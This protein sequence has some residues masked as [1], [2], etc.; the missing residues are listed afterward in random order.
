DLWTYQEIQRNMGHENLAIPH[1]GNVSDGWMFSP[2][3]FLGG[4]MDA[5]YA[6]RQAANEPV[7][8]MIQTKGSSDT[9]PYLSPNDEFA[10][11]ELFNNMIN[12]GMPSQLKHSFYRQGL[13]EG[14]KLEKLLGTNPYKMGIVAG[15]DI[16]SGYSGNEEWGWNG[17]HGS[18]D[19]T[20]AKRLTPGMNPSGEPASVVGSAGTTAIW[21][22]ENTRASLF[23]GMK[24]K[25]TYGTSGTMIRLRFFGGWELPSDL[26]TDP[27]FV[28]MAY[29]MGVPMGG[30]LKEKPSSVKAP[31]FAIWALKDSES[32][33]LDRIQIIKVFVNKWDR[34]DEK[35][36][37][38]ALSDGRKV[39]PKTGKA[40]D[41]GNTVN[42][43]KATYT[44]DIG[45]SQL[46]AVWTDPDFD[47]SQRASYYVRVLEIPT[48][49]WTT[50]DAARN[51]L[52]LP[53]DVPAVIQE[54]AWSSPIWYT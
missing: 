5:R 36:Y 7:F 13:G 31:S 28:K 6:E 8:E 32:G 35:I 11:F 16:H 45:D 51:N 2:N 50:Y 12:V 43:K 52:P 53:T 40:P 47:A 41:V 24:N 49:R 42:V 9:H 25:E 33:N 19:D 29:N 38:V 39:D 27:E 4:P 44:N 17:A 34:A 14:M 3:E 10:D 22:E 54:R 20:P 46:S 1:N 23:D 18:L 21:A 48:P 30:D 15:S 37:D 26:T